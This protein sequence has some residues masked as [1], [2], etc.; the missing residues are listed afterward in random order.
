M[1]NVTIYVDRD[2]ASQ[3]RAHDVKVSLTCQRALRRALRVAERREAR[4]T[5]AMHAEAKARE[6]AH[7]STRAPA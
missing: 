7:R 2:L 5:T 1:P 3:L 6:A 4:V